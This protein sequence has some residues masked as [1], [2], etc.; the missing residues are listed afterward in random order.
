MLY[1]IGCYFL[2]RHY[3]HLGYESQR[4]ALPMRLLSTAQQIRRRF[5][6]SANLMAPFPAKPK[7]MY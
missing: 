1:G 7:G 3:P 2:C 5:D 4:E 6:G